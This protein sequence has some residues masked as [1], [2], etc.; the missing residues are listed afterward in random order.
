MFGGSSNAPAVADGDRL[1]A[2]I[3]LDTDDMMETLQEN[4]K[5]LVGITQDFKVLSD[6]LV[7]GQ[8]TMGAL[9]KDSLMAENFRVYCK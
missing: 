4:N 6:R 9:L 5:N 1:Q 8:G 2:E 7:K 3:P